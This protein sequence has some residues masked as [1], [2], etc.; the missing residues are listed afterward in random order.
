VEPA[1][2]APS[3][4]SETPAGQ[5]FWPAVPQTL[6]ETGLRET[7]LESLVLKYLLNLGRASGREIA[8]QISLPF[9]LVQQLLASMKQSQLVSLKSDAPL[10]DYSYELTEFGGDNAR[11]HV[12][13]CTYFGAAPVT[14]EQYSASV[15]AQSLRRQTLSRDT[16][17]TA[18]ADLV[19]SDDALN[20]VGEALSMG[21]GMF[22]Y[23]APGN[24]KS[25]IG[26][27]IARVFT[28][29]IW[30]PRALTV[31]G[32]IL[33]LF[34]SIH[35]QELPCDE[36]DQQPYDPRWVRIR[37]P[38]I[39]VGGE[40]DLQSFDIT[41]NPITGISETPIQVKANCGTLVIDDFGRNRFRP[42]ELLNRLVVPMERGLD[43]FHL[44]SGRTF[45]VP[46][47]TMLVFAS[48][49]IPAAIVD[50][51]FLR[52]VPFKIEV[53]DPSPEQFRLL[54]AREAAQHGLQSSPEN[55]DYL[56]ERHYRA[57]GRP[58]RF[59]HPRDLMRIIANACQFHGT[60][61]EVTHELLDWAVERNILTAERQ[62]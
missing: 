56:L 16:V 3:S 50:E 54:F 48:N 2:V 35:H 13:R 22:L 14:L 57:V 39:V 10:G 38:A 32:E 29:P 23:G 28:R 60:T 59:C 51:A 6:E 52:R 31:G 17:R 49:E 8:Q 36:S 45:Q 7:Q 4:Q 47:D 33:R 18:F 42:T 30:V 12:E 26:E 1:P 15:L 37:R 62:S 11:R 61:P 44:A 20:V 27:R 19:M 43:S 25:C 46:F 5:D 41:T 34:D 58:L 55:V 40:L 9:R 53:H 21:R 24:G